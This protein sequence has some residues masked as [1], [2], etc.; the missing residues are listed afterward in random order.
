MVITWTDLPTSHPGAGRIPGNAT[1]AGEKANK[2]MHKDIITLNSHLFPFLRKE[3][4]SLQA[5]RMG[6][7]FGKERYRKF[8]I[9]VLLEGFEPG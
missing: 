5:A 9:G 3:R 7:S 6:R 2:S 8:E 1:M 4:E